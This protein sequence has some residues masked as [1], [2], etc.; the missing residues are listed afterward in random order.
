[1]CISLIQNFTQISLQMWNVQT[2]IHL[3]PEANCSCHCTDSHKIH[4]H[5]INYCGHLLYHIL[6]KSHDEYRKYKQNF[7]QIPKLSMNTAQIF[8][9]LTAVNNTTWKS[10]TPTFTTVTKYGN[11]IY[12]LQQS[13]NDTGSIFMTHVY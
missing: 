7:L 8:M 2:Q 11:P 12:S 6:F 9:Q 5:P 13:T 1:M 3:R 4:D 10:P